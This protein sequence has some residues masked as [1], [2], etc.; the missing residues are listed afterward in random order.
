M[1]NNCINETNMHM[2]LCYENDLYNTQK[3]T[4]ADTNCS[5]VFSDIFGNF[6]LHNL[7]FTYKYTNVV[8]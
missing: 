8:S 7:V 3:I 2:C 1:S 4:I 5:P 6:F